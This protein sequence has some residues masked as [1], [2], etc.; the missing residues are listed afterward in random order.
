MPYV[1]K[2]TKIKAR[3]LQAYPTCLTGAMMKMSAV[4][5]DISGTVRHISGTSSTDPNLSFFVDLDDQ[6]PSSVPQYDCATC[7]RKHTQIKA[8]NVYWADAQED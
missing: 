2:G 7:G 6:A 1:T 8:K 5:V 4:S 3:W